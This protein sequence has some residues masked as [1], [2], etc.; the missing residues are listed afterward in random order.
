[1]RYVAISYTG[2]D[3]FTVDRLTQGQINQI[4]ALGVVWSGSSEGGEEFDPQGRWQS[5]SD[6]ALE[7]QLTAAVREFIPTAAV[8]VDHE[9]NC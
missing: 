4:S 3:G 5:L 7:T 6:E 2:D 1:M 8:C 9:D